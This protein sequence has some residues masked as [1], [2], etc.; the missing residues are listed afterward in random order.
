MKYMV[1]VDGSAH[2]TKALDLAL[3]LAKGRESDEV[4]TLTVVDEYSASDLLD[5]EAIIVGGTSLP[6]S[7]VPPWRYAPLSG[8]DDQSCE[9]TSY[10]P[11]PGEAVNKANVELRTNAEAV[12]KKATEHCAKHGVWPARWRTD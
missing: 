6:P 2:A 12:M 4:V 5:E 9:L 7:N 11:T 8:Q 10:H 1:A 3:S